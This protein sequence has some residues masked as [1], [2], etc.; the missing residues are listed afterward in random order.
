VTPN[1]PDVGSDVS[2]VM[3]SVMGADVKCRRGVDAL[4]GQICCQQLSALAAMVAGCAEEIPGQVRG[5]GAEQ[6]AELIR[7]PVRVGD[8]SD[9]VARAF[10]LRIVLKHFGI[11]AA[12]IEL[13]TEFGGGEIVQAIAMKPEKPERKAGID[14][15]DADLGRTRLLLTKLLLTKLLP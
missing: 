13:G 7:P 5:A 3:G 6:L 11:R 8:E 2:S 14:V 9:V 15:V 12:E 1:A 10:E 4:F